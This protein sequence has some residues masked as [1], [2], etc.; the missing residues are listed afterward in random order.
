MSNSRLYLVFFLMF[1]GNDGLFRLTSGTD[2][3]YGVDYLVKGVALV[4]LWQLGTTRLADPKPTKAASTL[5]IAL[6]G[7]FA[8]VLNILFDKTKDYAEQVMPMAKLFS[9]PAIDNGL[10]LTL[11]ATFGLMLTAIVEELIFRRLAWHALANRLPGETSR[12]I[13]A[14]LLFGLI[15]WGNGPWAI[16]ATGL[17][18]AVLWLAYRRT[19]S[20]PL[21]IIAH[22]V[23]NA[24]VFY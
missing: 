1:V 15:H 6:W 11:D 22:Y 19:G 18:G 10:L 5:D 8:I 16:I 17:G 23:I 9:W 4:L 3:I 14:S 24:I 2:W 21:V 13:G 20:L 12:I 7:A